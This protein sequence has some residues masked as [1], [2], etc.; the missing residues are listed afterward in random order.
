MKK[1]IKIFS[2]IILILILF[3][4]LTG[5]YLKSIFT[6]EKIRKIAQDIVSK[7]I[8]DGQ[9]KLGIV[10]IYLGWNFKVKI[11]NLVLTNRA[12]LT[13][14]NALIFIK[15]L[16]LKLPI[17]S[18]FQ[19]TPEIKLRVLQVEI[20]SFEQL[21]TDDKKK[22]E[23]LTA[24]I[25][26]NQPSPEDM[27]FLKRLKARAHD[28]GD[29]L[30]KNSTLHFSSED[31]SFFRVYLK[32]KPKKVNCQKIEIRFESI[33]RPL[34]LHL[35][36]EG[37]TGETEPGLKGVITLDGQINIKE[38]IENK[39]LNFDGSFV[40]KNP[41]WPP[42]GN[43]PTIRGKVDGLKVNDQG[44]LVPI[45]ASVDNWGSGSL[46]LSNQNG[47]TV[48]DSVDWNF[49]I[50]ALDFLLKKMPFFRTGQFGIKGKLS[51]LEKGFY[52]EVD[53]NTKNLTLTA[54]KIKIPVS[55]L[56]KIKGK[57]FYAKTTAQI[58]KGLENS[59]IAGTIN[60]DNLSKPFGPM[61]IDSVISSMEF[62]LP[63]KQEKKEEPFETPIPS[64][65]LEL[66]I[67]MEKVKL[68]KIVI[69]G[70][71]SLSSGKNKKSKLSMKLTLSGAPAIIDAR[72]LENKTN[73]VIDFKLTDFDLSL[74][75]NLTPEHLG[76][77]K[78]KANLDFKGTL[79]F[80]KINTQDLSFKANLNAL[81]GNYNNPYLGENWKKFI[82]E[83]KGLEKYI[84]KDAQPFV[85]FEKVILVGGIDKG[86]IEISKFLF[87]APSDKL[88]VHANG[89]LGLD[90]SKKSLIY[91]DLRDKIGITLP[92]VKKLFGMETLYFKLLGNGLKLKPD[93]VYTSSK[94]L[95][96]T[97]TELPKNLWS[98]VD[99]L[100][101]DPF[102]K[103]EKGLK[104]KP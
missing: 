81:D 88:L 23:E 37:D 72:F 45:V 16:D 32:R 11:E 100:L 82:Q 41:N 102:R 17:Y 15:N 104:K 85:D 80:P 99:K 52:P 79:P 60:W 103:L 21:A 7:S 87:Q 6:E 29:T 5:L 101:I 63:K 27:S 84:S 34:S 93:L 56:G 22:K 70:T 4:G 55:I 67:K 86:N 1:F 51:F 8:P 28:F 44:V 18:I 89:N 49:N 58:F 91:L 92:G 71:G 40:L 13:R 25:R 24:P 12:E 36:C 9:L 97:A 74:L 54:E 94:V 19:K 65:P 3:F 66:K 69:N 26:Q 39:D 2:A 98:P 61:K 95:E 53:L 43:I 10:K 57:N 73:A 62:K 46:I 31:F 83:N 47:I 35:N 78:G 68:E 76:L 90:E 77:F 64:F 33:I 96:K 38:L 59:N 30:L 48:L 50:E 42:I 14:E 75:E 20:R